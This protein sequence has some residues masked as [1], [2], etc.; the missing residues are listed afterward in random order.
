[1]QEFLAILIGAVLGIFSGL[2]PGVHSNTI[3][4][5]LVQLGIEPQILGMLI[6]ATLAG[7]T[8]FEFLPAIFLGIPDENTVVSVLPGQRMLLQG[9]SAEAIR[10]CAFS[11]LLSTLLSLMLFPVSLSLFPLLFSFVEPLMLPFLLAASLF[12]LLTEKEIRRIAAGSLIF[13]LS[14]I[15]GFFVLNSPVQDPLFPAFTGLFAMSSLIASV[16]TRQEL[17][18]QKD[19]PFKLDFL[20]F[21]AAGVVLG[22]LADLFPGISAPA[23]IAVFASAFMAFD[24][25]RHYLALVSSIA[26]SHAIFGFSSL[27]A[28]NKARMGALVALRNVA[29]V[30]LPAALPYIAGFALVVGL[31]SLALLLFSRHAK[32]LVK[33]DFTQLNIVLILYL[34]G[35][36]LIIC[37]P[38]GIIILAASTAIGSLPLFLGVRRTH[39]MGLIIVPSILAAGAKAF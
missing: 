2:V 10:T 37:G 7:H 20:K 15:L 28:I 21:V 38:A 11:L 27:L 17:P 4:S 34:L 30:S 16:R 26:A 25:P 13:L 23:Q 19:G 39:V 9:R 3:T 29:E 5:I 33:V 8:V 32:E 22:M 6:I 14:G 36:V 35:L 24:E 18:E 1:M 12:L 31:A